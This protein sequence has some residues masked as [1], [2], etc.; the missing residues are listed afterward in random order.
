MHN[1]FKGKYILWFYN[2]TSIQKIL[3]QMH[4]KE[5]RNKSSL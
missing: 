2:F 5:I 3:V 1:E 4:L